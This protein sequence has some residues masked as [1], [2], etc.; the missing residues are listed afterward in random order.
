MRFLSRGLALCAALFAAGQALAT[1]PYPA[2]AVT[3]MV[4]YPAGGL[5]DVIARIVAEPLSKE[6]GQ[7]VVVENV[8]GATGAVAAQKVLSAP[9]DGYYLFQGTPSELIL[10]PWANPAVKFKAEDFRMVQMMGTAPLVIVARKD[11]PAQTPDELVQLARAS[12]KTKPLTFGSVGPGSLYHVLGEHLARTIGASMTHV[13]YKGGAP[14][15]QDLIGGQVDFAILALSQQQTG[16][17]ETG[18]V[19]LLGTLSPERL[20]TLPAVPSVTEGQL[21]RKFNFSI[22]T[23]YLVKQGT[24]EPVVQRLQAA[25]SKVMQDPRV[26]GQMQVQHVFGARPQTLKEAAGM[27]AFETTMYRSMAGAIR[28]EAQ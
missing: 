13:P 19:K 17:V 24:P 16:L 10:S 15:M 25:L 12:A 4:P 7:P 5:S 9:A 6:L 26:R 18:R 28:L 22:W 14:L 3:I 1:D 20:E 27:Y 23:G 2:K 8:G 21:M 11:L